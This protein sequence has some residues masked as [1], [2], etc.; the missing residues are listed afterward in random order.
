MTRVFARL[1]RTVAHHPRLTVVAWLV[2]TVL[3]Y[4]LAVQGVHGE[5][6]F[7]RVATGSPG[8]PGAESTRGLQILA[9]E[10]TTGPNVNL[11]LS[12]LDPAD[13]EV[14]PALEPARADLAAVDG[15][16][17]VIDPLVLPGGVTN[18]AAAPLLAQDGDG[19]LLVVELEPD[20]GGARQASALAAV[21]ERL[22]DVPG[23]L[24]AVAPTVGGVVGAE[25]L[26]VEEITQQVEDDLR[27][28]ELV[29]L[30]IA[31]LIMVVVFGGFLA[32]G[33]PM[34]GALASIAGGLGALLA[35]TYVM[36]VDAS[37]VNVVT[38]LGLGLSIDYGLL[39][40][41]RYREELHRT[42]GADDGAG[43]RR[44]RGDGAVVTAVERT[45][46]T[47][48]R[49]VV[50]SAVTVAVSIA[51][52]LVFRPDILRAVGAGGVAVVLVAV[53]TAVT[54]VPALLVL[55]GRRLARPGLLARVPGLRRA[56][57]VGAEEGAFSSLAGR[58]QRHPWWVMLGSVAL[59][60]LLASPA[61]HMQLRISG[62]ELLPEGTT[63]RA[64]VADLEENYPAASS[65]AVTV[66]AAA[67]LPDATA[68]TDE[69]AELPGVV[70]VDPP[71]ALGAYVVIGVR[72][73]TDD[74]GGAVAAD[75]VR[76]VRGLDAP[77]ERWVVG[78]AASQIDFTDALLARAPIALGIVG[79]ATLVL[80]FLMT[81]SVVIPVKALVTN[82]LS[83]VASLGVLVW[84]F[85]DGHL[86]G[87][88]GF[89]STGGIETYVLAL[90]IAF[91]F[92]LAMDYEVFLLARIKELYDTGMPTDR[93]VLLGLQRS[94]RIITSAAAIIIV[95][96][97]GFV[98]GDLVV[99]KQ[100]GFA[101]A[102][103]VLIDATL[104]RLLLVPA[105]M[106]VLDRANWW[107]PRP[108]RR[109]YDRF[110][111]IH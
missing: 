79:A 40:V 96:F 80:L 8:V 33:M 54:L 49:T 51:G 109:L 94:G 90:V 58:V 38:V 12:G 46:A 45:M 27:T 100:V 24:R 73:D 14:G 3:G 97:A 20:L 87:L 34:A 84:A 15:V 104:V 59:L 91:A 64:Y 93:A 75:V 78:Q 85:Q 71:A 2:L 70:A 66:V 39:I 86:E 74:P 37:V 53:A 7:D 103:A 101:L 42:V 19:F 61:L 56:S 60:A 1:G 99:I 82:A 29:A 98:A 5:N 18:P 26:I 47:A 9:D 69:L 106:T 68:W 36:D 28:G 21:E 92:G 52:L 72:A 25:H 6:L 43:S 102:F 65:A 35:L 13:P 67:S 50:F 57:D 16:A 110:A 76:E 89:T 4:A 111:I 11:V 55:T 48:G 77:F 10:R 105:T 63:Q 31:L 95:V 83:I 62:L 44:R 30:P 41:S 32:A 17:S 23:E 22:A 108:L 88:L 107:A 81:G